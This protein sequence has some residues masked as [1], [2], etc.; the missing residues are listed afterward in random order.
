MER[1]TRTVTLLEIETPNGELRYVAPGDTDAMAG[2][3]VLGIRKM[4]AEMPLSVFIAN[5]TI[6]EVK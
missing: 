1:I 6:K 2:N 4:Y 5:A 3:K